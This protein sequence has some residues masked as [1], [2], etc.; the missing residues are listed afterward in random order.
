MASAPKD[1]AEPAASLH[2]QNKIRRITPEPPPKVTVAI[3]VYN[4]ANYLRDAISSCLGQSYPNLEVIVVN[5]G[6]DDHGETEAIAMQFTPSI[7][8]LTK[9]NGGEYNIK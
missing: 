4:G 7:I 5:D 3:P 6:S 2:T 9:K 1:H 8:Y